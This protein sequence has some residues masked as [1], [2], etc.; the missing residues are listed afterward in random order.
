M[1]KSELC[2]VS[3]ATLITRNRVQKK[4]QPKQGGAHMAHHPEGF[5]IMSVY[6]LSVVCTAG[7]A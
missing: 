1:K 2:S 4:A 7:S 6:S 5:I 3:I